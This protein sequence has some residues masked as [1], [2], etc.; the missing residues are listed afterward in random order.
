MENN[1]PISNV[2]S[3]ETFNAP[4]KATPCNPLE[5]N[6]PLFGIGSLIYTI[7]FVFCLYK[8]FDS[9]TSP[10]LCTVTICY[11]LFC[12]KTLNI[13]KKKGDFLFLFG[14]FLLSLSNM[15]TENY[16]LIFLNYC[17][18]IL[19]LFVYLIRHFYETRQWNFSKYFASLMISMCFSVSHVIDPVLGLRVYMKKNNAK[20]SSALLSIF[21]GLCV[22]V[23]LLLI[24]G[25]LLLSADAVFR[26]VIDYVFK[27]FFELLSP[28]PLVRIVLL[29]LVGMGA[30]FGLL[31]EFVKKR[32]NDVCPDTRT[33][34]PLIAITFTSILTVI[35]L[36]FS[37]IQILYLFIGNMTLPKGYTY[38]QYAR[39]GFFQLLFVC[40]INLVLVLFCSGRFKSSKALNVILTII[41]GC[42][43]IMIASSTMRMSLYIT[44]YGLTFTR[45]FVLLALFVLLL[46]LVGIVISIYKQGF[47]LFSY[48]LVIVSVSY[49]LFSLAKPDY[50]IATYNIETHKNNIYGTNSYLYHLSADAAPVLIAH[51][52]YD[53][54]TKEEIELL[55]S[56]DTFSDY[57]YTF[58]D[59]YYSKHKVTDS[60]SYDMFYS[61]Y[62]NVHRSK[63]MNIRTFNVSAYQAKK[64]IEGYGNFR[65]K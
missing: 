52:F 18:I 50:W 60:R 57:Y 38:A 65:A 48:M 11:Y 3:D 12:F 37:V 36:I 14:T 55:E 10:I 7:F 47:P 43:L 31:A 42:T 16:V 15:L 26:T 19:L 53:D 54:F 39:E 33:L 56:W 13:E 45:V 41:C 44:A 8:N 6:F 35:Y 24:I 51:G 32:V 30:S 28:A 1:I 58:R 59:S 34:D 17:G 62:R 49:I 25:G 27:D 64:A 21:I 20:K 29:F 23:P 4:K 2:V 40:L 61:L 46:C 9:V 22:S 5:E 63:T